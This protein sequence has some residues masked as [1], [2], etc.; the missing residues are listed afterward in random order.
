MA[1]KV[2]VDIMDDLDG[3]AGAATTEFGLDGTTYEIDLSES[4][5]AKLRGLLDDYIRA[6]RRSGV[7]RRGGSRNGSPTVRRSITT[8]RDMNEKIRSWARQNGHKIADRGRIPAEVIDA[9]HARQYSIGEPAKTTTNPTFVE[10]KKG[11][12][13]KHDAYYQ[14]KPPTGFADK[15]EFN[16]EL[17]AWAKATGRQCG[18]QPSNALKGEWIELYGEPEIG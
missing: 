6:A 9:Y 12:A 18:P 8:D 14:G 5:I 16:A 10:P 2:T 7:A 15:K 1:Q 3:S 4:N 13:V 17:R 11:K